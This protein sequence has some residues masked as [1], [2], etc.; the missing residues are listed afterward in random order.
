LIEAIG[1]N[2]DREGLKETPRRVAT[3]FDEIFD[4]YKYKSEDVFNAFFSSES[5]DMVIV[6]NIDFDSFCE[7]HMVPF[8]GKIHIGYIPDPHTKKVVGLSK[9]V[10]LINI[11][12]HRL[13]LQERL[14]SQIA[15]AIFANKE[16]N[17]AGVMVVVEAQHL[18]MVMRGVKNYNSMT[19]TSAVRGVFKERNF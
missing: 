2:P 1:E 3:M 12:A 4:G 11:F 10:R 14:T 18:C 15:N 6:K 8:S 9:F 13:Q 16:L 7:H 17:P 19:I 5:D